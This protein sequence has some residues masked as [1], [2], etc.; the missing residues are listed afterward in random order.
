MST[1]WDL[2]FSMLPQCEALHTC[3]LGFPITTKWCFDEDVTVVPGA[4]FTKRMCDRCDSLQKGGDV[5]AN[6]QLMLRWK[7]DSPQ[8][9]C[10]QRATQI[11]VTW[12]SNNRLISSGDLYYC[13][14]PQ[15]K[16]LRTCLPSFLITTQKIYFLVFRMPN[17]WKWPKMNMYLDLNLAAVQS[18][19]GFGCYHFCL[20]RFGMELII[21][22]STSSQISV[23]FFRDY[24]LLQD[25][26]L[27]VDCSHQHVGT[28]LLQEQCCVA[29]SQPKKESNRWSSAQ[30]QLRLYIL[31]GSLFYCCYEF[32][33]IC[34]VITSPH[35]LR[36]IIVA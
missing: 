31:P 36:L 20:N 21:F 12:T 28:Y 34:G 33:V 1:T 15:R 13:L 35:G 2:Y 23:E 29:L 4:T 9:G 30:K 17:T 25:R 24:R 10:A 18:I 3:L 19:D 27:T 11:Y 22:F 32:N 26:R 14:L 7:C 6:S 8:M 5:V 16:A